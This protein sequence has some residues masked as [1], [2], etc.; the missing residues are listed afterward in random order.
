MSYVNSCLINRTNKKKVASPR[1]KPTIFTN[2]PVLF[3]HS[4]YREFVTKF[5]MTHCGLLGVFFFARE[6]RCVEKPYIVLVESMC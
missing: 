4:D 2:V 1:D 3:F 5:L 6:L